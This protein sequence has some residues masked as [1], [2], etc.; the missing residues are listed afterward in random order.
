MHRKKFIGACTAKDCSILI[1]SN[2]VGFLID[3]MDL[4]EN[5]FG[6]IAAILSSGDYSLSRARRARD[7][8]PVAPGGVCL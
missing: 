2:I 7:C 4:L 3:E 5:S 6:G 8:R 1:V